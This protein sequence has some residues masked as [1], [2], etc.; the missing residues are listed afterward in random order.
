MSEKVSTFIIAC[1]SSVRTL[2]CEQNS[3]WDLEPMHVQWMNNCA[4][5]EKICVCGASCA[6]GEVFVSSGTRDW[7]GFTSKTKA[8]RSNKL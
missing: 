4:R 1:P 3:S 8:S 2:W 6:H 5:D 7:P